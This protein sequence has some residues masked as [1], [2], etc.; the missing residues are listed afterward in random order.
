MLLEERILWCM[1]MMNFC[2]L[3]LTSICLI[4]LT[5]RQD[6]AWRMSMLR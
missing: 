4:A 2:V 3:L 5:L 6:F 1:A